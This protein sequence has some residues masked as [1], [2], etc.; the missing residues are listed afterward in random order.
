M[1]VEPDDDDDDAEDPCVT[2]EYPSAIEKADPRLCDLDAEL[3][4]N[5]RDA[6]PF[7]ISAKCMSGVGSQ[8]DAEAANQQLIVSHQ[9]Y[10]LDDLPTRVQLL[11][12]P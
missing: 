7:R 8:L 12:Q 5:F 11:Q 2:A 4:P 3:Y 6:E 1:D 10:G 9:G